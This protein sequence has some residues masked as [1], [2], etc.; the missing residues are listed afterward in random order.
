[1]KSKTTKLMALVLSV[2]MLMAILPTM[3]FAAEESV[4]VNTFEGLKLALSGNYA[5]ITC[6]EPMIG[7]KEDTL[8][9]LEGV[10]VIN[11][12]QFTN[13]G[14]INNYGEIKI[15]GDGLINYGTINNYGEIIINIWL[16]NR[17]T[18]NN[19][20][21]NIDDDRVTGAINNYVQPD[22][23]ALDDALAAAEGFDASDYTADTWAVLA[24]AVADGK[25]IDRVEW[26]FEA[27]AVILQQALD[28]AAD[29]IADAILALEINVTPDP[30]VVCMATDAKS[31]VSLVEITKGVWQVNITVIKTLDNG[32]TVEDTIEVLVP[33]NGSGTVDLGDYV[34][35]YDIKGNGSNV[36][37]LE[38]VKK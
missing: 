6:V 2:L 25:A 28:N 27:D 31:I 38:I 13:N 30:E 20:G 33:K 32:A 17:G 4:T 26:V 34:L 1:M 15:N 37:T 19:Y 10:T 3:A 18:I 5:I 23:S 14:E 9:I 7:S 8:V 11:E 16:H 35:V 24:A 21:G 22:Y 12:S 36:K 29:A